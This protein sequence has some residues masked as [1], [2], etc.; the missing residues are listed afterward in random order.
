[1]GN[2]NTCETI[3]N[4]AFEK[5]ISQETFNF[6]GLVFQEDQKPLYPLSKYCQ[7]CAKQRFTEE[8]IKELSDPKLT[9]ETFMGKYGH[10]RFA[11]KV[12]CESKDCQEKLYAL[13]GGYNCYQLH[14]TFAWEEL[15]E[16]C[17]KHPGRNIHTG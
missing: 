1:M 13:S 2:Q 9:M 3:L 12:I 8:E 14:T 10:L 17:K 15:Q 7:I 16:W 6:R 11:A 5:K 4:E